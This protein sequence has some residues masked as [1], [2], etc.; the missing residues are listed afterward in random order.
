[1]QKISKKHITP[2]EVFDALKSEYGINMS[3]HMFRACVRIL[4]R[5]HRI[6]Q[7][8]AAYTLNNIG[9]DVDKYESDKMSLKEH[10]LYLL[11]NLI[12][13]AATYKQIW[14]LDE[15]RVYLGNYLLRDGNAINLFTNGVIQATISIKSVSP[16]WYIQSF[17][18]KI[19]S[20]KSLSVDYLLQIVKGLMIYIGVYETSCSNQEIGQKFRGTR[21]I[22][23]TRLV[24]RALGFSSEFEVKSI[25][26]LL[27]LIRHEYNGIVSVFEHTIRE[28]ELA[29]TS[30]SQCLKSG[31][32]IQYREMRWF[33]DKNNYDADDFAIC[34]ATVRVKLSEMGFQCIDSK[35]EW[36]ENDTRKN[37]IDDNSLFQYIKE[38]HEHWSNTAIQNDIDAINK[39]NILRKSDY[40]IA[41]GGK[42]HLPIFITSNIAL[43]VGLREYIATQQ[44]SDESLSNWSANRLPIISDSLLMCRLWMPK[45]NRYHNLPALTLARDAYIAQQGNATFYDK[46]A[47]EI[48]VVCKKHRVNL[49][50][51]DDVRRQKLEQIIVEKSKGDID[52]ID[53]EMV[54]YSIDEL[55]KM[56][57][58][59]DKNEIERLNR[60]NNCSHEIMEKQQSSHSTS[61]AKRFTERTGLCRIILFLAR[62]I[63]P[64]L[65]ILVIT[66]PQVVA[67]LIEPQLSVGNIVLLALPV[68][69]GIVDKFIDRMQL[70]D[71]LQRCLVDYAVKKK[72]SEVQSNLSEDEASLTNSVIEKVLKTLPCLAW[73]RKRDS[74][75]FDEY[76]QR[77][78][79]NKNID[80]SESMVV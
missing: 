32:V 14:S 37:N 74:K 55:I 49:V 67:Y 42:N 45:A 70:I 21:F 43:I 54:A 31:R 56:E 68:L 16:D 46:L 7:V 73:Y 29:L 50:D 39:V 11:R 15:A 71:K 27:Y 20:E 59:A 30:A 9:F 51:I 1:M 48:A 19:Q 10:E 6:I 5:T 78:C 66:V 18:S 2:Q 3:N 69:F 35:I 8:S 12:D 17:I 72:V 25:N 76:I 63:W 44:V 47:Q 61:I 60:I 33:A 4:E 36:N 80:A 41:F 64:V 65:I 38:R 22:F 77:C 62:W 58:S 79:D 75:A 23:D 13:F 26:E 24:L 57:Q 28:V 53:D 52:S 34:S 40:S